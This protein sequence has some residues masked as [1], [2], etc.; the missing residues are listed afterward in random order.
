MSDFFSIW[1]Y[2]LPGLGFAS[3][4]GLIWGSFFNVCIVRIPQ[5]KSVVRNRSHC[6]SCHKSLKWYHNIPVLSYVLLGGKCA[7]CKAPISLQYPLVEI[8]SAVFFAYLWWIYGWSPSWLCYTVFVSMLLIITVIDLKHMIIPDEL[9]LSGIV[10]GL[11]SVFFT[12]DIVWWESL[13]GAALGGGIFLGI[14]LLYEKLTKQEGLGG[15]DIKLLAMI[16]AWLGIQSVLIVIIISS[17]LGS[18]VGLSLILTKR[19]NLKTAIPFGPFLAIAAILYLLWGL[20]L[21][22][23]LFPSL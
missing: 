21:R 13:L 4:L 8:L 9:S 14:A 12:G 19:K 20:P 1:D 22:R 6:Q 18:L 11:V 3:L 10:L 5:D 23:A 15:G 17:A 2:K 7:F 16:G